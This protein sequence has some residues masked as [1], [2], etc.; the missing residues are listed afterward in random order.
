MTE[1]EA[2]SVAPV[3]PVKY[4]RPLRLLVL[5]LMAMSAV[6]I[7]ASYLL[8]HGSPGAPNFVTGEVYQ[9][10][11]GG[12]SSRDVFVTFESI[13]ISRFFLAHTVVLLFLVVGAAAW[14]MAKNVIADSRYVEER[15][16]V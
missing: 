16:D 14:R 10:R 3:I 12:R 11:A 1:Q 2:S 5:Y 4:Q 8:T 13:M 6:G 7:V 15:R 9:M